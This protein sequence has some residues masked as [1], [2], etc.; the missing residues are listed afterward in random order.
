[1]GRG[2]KVKVE[3]QGWARV[4]QSLLQVK[5]L[6]L[7]IGP[8]GARNEEVAAHMT[9]G[10]KD[11]SGSVIVPARPFLEPAIEENAEPIAALAGE[12]FEDVITG[13]GDPIAAIKTLGEV[14]VSVVKDKIREGDPTWEPLAPETVRRKGHA[15]ALLDSHAMFDSLDYRLERTSKRSGGRR[16]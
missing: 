15:R 12:M 7:T 14:V 8:E 9:F 5:G 2:G 10:T 16:R 4:R 1:M 6:E 3:D 11:A 13:R